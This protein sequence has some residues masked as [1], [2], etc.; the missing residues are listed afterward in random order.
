MTSPMR[1]RAVVCISIFSLFAMT[2]TG[3]TLEVNGLADDGSRFIEH[4][5][6]AFWELGRTRESTR[7][8]P[9]QADGA[10]SYA[11]LPDHI[12]QG[13]GGTGFPHRSEFDDL[14]AIDFDQSTGVITGLEFDFE[15]HVAPGRFTFFQALAGA[16]PY[17]TSF[18]TF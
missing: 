13:G 17:T 8:P 15:P 7:V 12:P 6:S 11:A 16:S 2:A 14:G 5:Q 10:F 3:A 18:T 1:F 9:G 4:R